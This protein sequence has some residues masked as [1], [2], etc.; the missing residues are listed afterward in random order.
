[1]HDGLPVPVFK[2]A[3]SRIHVRVH[4]HGILIE[5]RQVASRQSSSQDEMRMRVSVTAAA[6]LCSGFNDQR[7]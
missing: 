7:Q 1:M 5:F 6:A 4:V 3:L 2:H